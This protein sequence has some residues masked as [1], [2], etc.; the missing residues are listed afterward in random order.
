M[1]GPRRAGTCGRSW[2]NS[3]TRMI[4]SFRRLASTLA[5]A[6]RG[7]GGVRLQ[8]KVRAVSCQHTS[9]LVDLALKSRKCLRLDAPAAEQA[10]CIRRASPSFGRRESR[11]GLDRR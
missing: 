6:E 4:V 2:P 5:A 1:C 10:L 3:V 8:V 9:E 7:V 11:A